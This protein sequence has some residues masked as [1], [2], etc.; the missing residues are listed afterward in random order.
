MNGKKAFLND[1]VSKKVKY[2]L[3]GC[4]SSPKKQKS[5]H[6]QRFFFEVKERGRSES[7]TTKDFYWNISLN[8]LGTFADKTKGSFPF[9]MTTSSSILMPIPQYLEMNKK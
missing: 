6:F 2:C 7:Q 8:S 9:L 1:N 3:C 5:F 4:F